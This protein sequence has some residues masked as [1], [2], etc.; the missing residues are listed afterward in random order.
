MGTNYRSPSVLGWPAQT[1][2]SGKSVYP[3]PFSVQA[4]EIKIPEKV[5]IGLRRRG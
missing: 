5:L 3:T 4:I 2:G 1:E